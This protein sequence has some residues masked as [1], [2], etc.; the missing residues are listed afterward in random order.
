MKVTA[1]VTTYNRA[2]LVV[3]AVESVLAQE[4]EDK[5]VLVIDNGSSDDTRERLSAYDVRYVWQEN[6]G[7]AGGRNRAIAEAR[8]DYI[9]FLDSDDEWLP[10]K[11]EREVAV[12]DGHPAVGLVHGHVEVVDA[13]GSALTDITELHRRWF[14]ESPAGYA[15]W[16]LR[17]MCLTSATMM[18][19][20]LLDELGGYDES[21]ELEDLDLYLRI[22][23]A[24]KVVFLGGAPLARYRWHEGQTGDEAL[25][26]GQIAV[27]KKHLELLGETG[28]RL[29]RRNFCITLARSHHLLADG[30]R[31][32]HWTATAVRIAPSALLVPGVVRRFL[33]SFVPRGALLRARAARGGLAWKR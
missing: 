24:S 29:A 2:D 21:M 30:P 10:G 27:C 23:A 7:R 32:R 18:R 25:T 12:L 4:F 15:E 3:A 8:G 19:R 16:A 14:E 22:V 31:V 26:R 1:A 13:R 20:S 33:L 11:L 28:D 5:E 6:R 9:A 17:C